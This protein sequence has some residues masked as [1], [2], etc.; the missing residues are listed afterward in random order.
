[1]VRGNETITEAHACPLLTLDR[2]LTCSRT[3]MGD[4]P[5]AKHAVR[6]QAADGWVR[7]RGG[8]KLPMPNAH[9]VTAD[10]GARSAMLVVR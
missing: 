10:D 8:G 3:N 2:R 4:L 1:M 9:G 7:S 5:P 6:T